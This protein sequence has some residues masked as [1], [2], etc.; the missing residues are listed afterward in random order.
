[1]TVRAKFR[2]A[3]V[4]RH[5]YGA[6]NVRMLP[7]YDGGEDSENRTFWQASPSG[8]IEMHINNPDAHGIFE[9]GSEFY[10]DFTPAASPS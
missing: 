2:V 4:E 8:K 9:P 1:M 3:S 10:I 5:E 7:V 6:E